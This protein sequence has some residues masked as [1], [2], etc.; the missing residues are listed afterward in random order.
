MNGDLRF[1]L[2]YQRLNSFTEDCF[3]LQTTDDTLDAL[4]WAKWFSK[5]DLMNVCLQVVMHS[6]DKDE[7]V[8]YTRQGLW[9]FKAMPFGLSIPP[10]MFKTLMPIC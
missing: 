7:T 9:H 8:F 6:S 2:D 5:L 3:L 4:A 10:E 1:C